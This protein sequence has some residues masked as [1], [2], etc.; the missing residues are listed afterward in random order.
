M[1]LER[2]VRDGNRLGSEGKAEVRTRNV[3]M[4]PTLTSASQD[5][6]RGHNC[7]YCRRVHS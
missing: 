3:A 1:A 7:R 4:I 2:D 6:A 5:F